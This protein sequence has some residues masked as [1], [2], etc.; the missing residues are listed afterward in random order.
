VV[1]SVCFSQTYYGTFVGMV[2]DT[3]GAVFPGVEVSITNVE[4]NITVKFPTNEAGNYRAPNLIPGRYTIS[5]EKPGFKKFVA[6]NVQ[7]IA[8]GERRVD[9]MLEVGAVTESVTVS[10]GAQ[11]VETEKATFSD[12]KENKVFTYM[13][14]NSNYRSI[15]RMLD[16]TPGANYT[17][18]SNYAGNGQ[19]RNTTYTIDGIKVMDGWTGNSFGPS[20]TYMDS[21]RE[22]RF[23]LVSANASAPTSANISVISDSGTNEVHGEAWLHYNAIGFSARPFFAPARPHGPPIFRPNVKAG[24][25]LVIPKVY[26]GKDRTFLH[27]SWQGLRGSQ[28]PYTANFV[29]PTQQFRNG[30]FS[31]IPGVLTDPT[32]G[33]PFADKKIPANRISSVSKYY[34][35]K[36]YPLPTSGDR[37]QNIYVFPNGSDQYTARTDHRVSDKNSLFGRFQR[38]TY[39]YKQYDGGTNPNVGIY[40]QWRDQ[41]VVG[42]SD[43]HVFT[44]SLINELRL[45]YGR[46]DSLYGGE[47]MGMEIVKDSGLILKD[48]EDVRALPRMDITG[49]QSI[50]QGDQNG[51][52]WSNYHF[53]E[54]LLWTK[55]KHNFRFGFD[56]DN[57]N[58]RQWA[59][60]PSRVFG[61]YNF[62][63][64]FS[65]NPY[66]DFLL[67]I[68]NT[69][70]RNTS[71]GRVYPHRTNHE[72]YFTD[73]WKITPRLSLSYGLRYSLLDPGKVEQDLIAN[74]VPWANALVVPTEEAKA[75][76][77]PGFPTNVPIKTASQVGLGQK[78]L[79]RDNDNFAPRFG[80][81][82]RPT[83]SNNFVIRGG[84]GVYNLA[85]QPYISDGG[86][87]PYELGETFT[88]SITNGRPDFSFPEPFPGRT[89]Q[90]VGTSASGMNPYT[91]TPYS[92]QYNLT[93]EKEV[94][95][96]GLS[97]TYMSTR[98]R[99][100]VWNRN[101]N[102]PPANTT[103]Y[104]QKLPFVP[105]TYL[106]TVTFSENGGAHNYN[107]GVI[108]AERRFKSG[109]YYQAHLTLAKSVAD[110]WATSS[111]DAFDRRRE[112]SQGGAIPR[113]RGVVIGL[114]ELPFGHGK[115]FGSST[116]GILN[117]LINNWMVA[118]TY[119]YRTGV[120]VTPAFSGSDPSNT[121]RFGGRP[122]RVANG[123]FSED[124]RTLQRW[125]DTTAFVAPPA[126]VGRF[127]T[128]GANVIEGPSMSVFHFGATKEIQI[129]EQ[130]RLKLEMVSTNFFNHPNFANPQLTLGT[131]TY[132]QILGTVGTDGNRDFQLTARFVF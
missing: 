48:L 62:N 44:P 60:S 12:T 49:F 54:N 13:P 31:S 107:A 109:L 26:N 39:T 5:A 81:A 85:M 95:D 29:V 6:E 14:V 96:M 84:F 41:Y 126:G 73:D 70:V 36:F 7:L 115:K 1:A 72:L 104:L 57:F 75:R 117:H 112:R 21:Y 37:F 15:W 2:T 11:L 55:G 131:S 53:T 92:M 98:L 71:V 97:A 66:A 46:D 119:V 90:L 8:L 111:E 22:F 34:Q 101:L 23:D 61:T 103:P 19:G 87:A 30:D 78:L 129:R 74:F 86:G 47:Q 88:N 93:F 35:D 127:G 52:T 42:F 80:F 20:L 27:F 25:P 40:D 77:H 99:K 100:N 89:Y 38:Q 105:F 121:N 79:E 91:R 63:G 51:W 132:G 18:G 65:G 69:S 28:N 125:F 122:D 9:V 94:F 120:Y 43:T 108:K 106:N 24:M 64:R 59:T 45:G 67:G 4:T 114:Y 128:S 56:R 82:W 118:G 16:L 76:I 32:T 83:T 10:G 110:D 124:G 123:N 33:L 17:S 113:W 3:S 102:Q 116:P 50:Y 68:M 58:G 130:M